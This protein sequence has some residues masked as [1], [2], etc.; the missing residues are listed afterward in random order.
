M[1]GLK[2]NHVSKRGHWWAFIQTDDY[3]GPM[4]MFLCLHIT[5]PYFNQYSDIHDSIEIINASRVHSVKC[6][7]KVIL[8]IIFGAKY[9][10]LYI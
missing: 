6:V 3:Y 9:G 2:L 7:S 8:S 10:A 4:A 5:V 1:L